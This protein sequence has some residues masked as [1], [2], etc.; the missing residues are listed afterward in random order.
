MSVAYP[1]TNSGSFSEGR[2]STQGGPFSYPP[3]PPTE[4]PS[5]KSHRNRWIAAAAAGSA[6][7]LA[8]LTGSTVYALDHKS[9]HSRAGLGPQHNRPAAAAP[10]APSPTE[11]ANAG[12]ANGLFATGDVSANRPKLDP[13]YVC[14]AVS[15]QYAAEVLQEPLGQLQPGCAADTDPSAMMQKSL[16]GSELISDGI[17]RDSQD[18]SRSYIVSIYWDLSGQV[19]QTELQN[20]GQPSAVWQ[21]VPMSANQPN[22]N[23]SEDFLAV[24]QND[25]SAM[26]FDGSYVLRIDTSQGFTD[27][28]YTALALGAVQSVFSAVRPGMVAAENN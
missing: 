23:Q 2:P 7:F 3:A 15:A 18:P 8:G 19:R 21:Q 27:A 5:P 25:G 17:W 28:Q 24:A 14:N 26:V 12:A 9:S 4:A 22:T 20:L 13:T 6:L 10:L 11:T 16:D 1:P